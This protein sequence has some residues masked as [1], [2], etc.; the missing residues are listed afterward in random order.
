MAIFNISY[1][2]IDDQGD[3]QRIQVTVPQGALTLAN[4]TGYAQALA[5]LIDDVIDGYISDISLCLVIGLPGGM[6]TSANAGAE[7]ERGANFTFQAD[8]TNYA[9]TIRVPGVLPGLFVG[10]S[11]DLTAG[12]VVALRAAL[13]SGL[14]IG[15]TQVIPSDRYENDLTNLIAATKTFRRK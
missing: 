1:G 7:V 14:N 5:A 10:N 8:G 6:K 3:T 2:V 11:V 13:T 12:A 4:I 15:G 9:H